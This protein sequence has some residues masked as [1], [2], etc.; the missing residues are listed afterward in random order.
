[1]RRGE[2]FLV[3]AL[4]GG[5][6]SA[7]CLVAGGAPDPEP[8]PSS[9]RAALVA[10]TLQRSGTKDQIDQVPALVRAGLEEQAAEADPETYALLEPIF[11]QAYRPDRLYQVVSGHL[12]QQADE[13]RLS[14]VLE[15]LRSPLAQRISGWEVEASTPEAQQ[16]VR[17]YHE[18]QEQNPPPEVRMDLVVRLNRAARVSETTVEINLATMRGLLEGVNASLP[19]EKRLEK[20]TLDR[21]LEGSRAQME[22]VTETQTLTYLLYTY[23]HATEPELT[24]Y[25]AFLESDLGQW[26]ARL[27]SEALRQAMATAANE[28]GRRVSETISQ[29]FSDGREDGTT[30]ERR[31]VVSPVEP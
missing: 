6:L 26:F 15:W 30:D 22:G 19:P 14:Q 2:G 21:L 20:E 31:P 11:S 25:V 17:R 5:L 9:D 16:E 4:A 18:Q 13:A 7:T 8:P 23:R 1:M 3:A 10:E 28:V 24:E 29:K 27:M 12:L